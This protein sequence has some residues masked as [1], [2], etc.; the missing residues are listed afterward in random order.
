MQ[1][2]SDNRA[3]T[4]PTPNRMRLVAKANSSSTLEPSPLTL[5]ERVEACCAVARK[6]LEA[7]DYDAGCA[8]LQPWWTLGEWPRPGGLSY[9][10]MA[11]LLLTA[12]MLSGLIASS[13]NVPEGQKPAEGL[14][15]GAL[16]LFEL[17]GESARAAEAR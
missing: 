2:I 14:L 5:S 13:R 10:A 12:G 6:K 9:Q 3:R 16:A 7:G 17:L 15:S 1:C 8:A 4:N 11:N